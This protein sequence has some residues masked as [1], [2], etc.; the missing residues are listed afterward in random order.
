MRHVL[1]AA[2][3]LLS[4]CYADYVADSGGVYAGVSYGTPVSVSVGVPPPP[5][6]YD[7]FL[8]CGYGQSFVQGHWDW[9]GSWYWVPGRC[10]NAPS[11]YVYIG[12]RYVGGVYTRG[13]WG[14]RGRTYVAPAPVYRAPAYRPPV[15]VPP[16]APAYRAPVYTPAPVYRPAPPPVYRAPV[17]TPPPAPAYRSPTYVPPPAPA[18]RAPGVRVVAPPAP[19]VRVVPP[20]APVIR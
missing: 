7:P 9:N 18:Y 2:A 17:Y 20:P 3:I 19:G 8:N 11:G 14:L 12:P 4:G 1:V 15:Y 13:Y 6:R 16:P 10:L 5:P